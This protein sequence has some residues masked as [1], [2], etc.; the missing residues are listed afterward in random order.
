MEFGYRRADHRDLMAQEVHHSGSCLLLP[1]LEVVLLD[2][3]ESRSCDYSIQFASTLVALS[4]QY[5]DDW[6]VSGLSHLE[7]ARLKIAAHSLP[8]SCHPG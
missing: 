3:P 6:V 5:R 1:A 8:M 7:L 4:L 2:T